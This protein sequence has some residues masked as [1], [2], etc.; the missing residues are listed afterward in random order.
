[1]IPPNNNDSYV[2]RL[3]AILEVEAQPRPQPSRWA[4]MAHYCQEIGHNVSQALRDRENYKKA[5]WFLG[6]NV[7]FNGVAAGLT[8]FFMPYLLNGNP[9][10]IVPLLTTYGLSLLI[11]EWTQPFVFQSNIGKGIDYVT[12]ALLYPGTVVL[13]TAKVLSDYSKPACITA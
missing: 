4:R 7:T 1:M 5:G 8:F 11:T 6:K 13:V 2:P 3:E 10:A 12:S 9:T